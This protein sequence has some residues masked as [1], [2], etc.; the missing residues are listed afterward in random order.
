MNVRSSRV[1]FLGSPVDS[2]DMDEALQR[3]DSFIQSR[4]VHLVVAFNVPK[5]CKMRRDA[6]LKEVVEGADLILPE[7]VITLASRLCG[8][9]LKA[10]IGNDRLTEA[11]LPSASRKGYRVFFLGTEPARL[12]R[13]VHNLHVRYPE[14]PIAGY[15]HGYFRDSEVDEVREK[16]RASRPDILFVGMGTPRQEYWME[17]CGRTLGVP[18]II[19]VGG[20][21]D[22]MA[23]IKRQC[24][25]W[26]RN[27]GLEW[28]Y[29]VAED[30][31]GK[32]TRY[33]SALP[34]FVK[35]LITKGLL[36]RWLTN[37]NVIEN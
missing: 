11:L 14:L 26:I 28:A 25:D 9:R 15:H 30:P 36:P 16:I 20:T 34:W 33:T 1:E 13:M 4:S 5:L 21:L 7:Q 27:A 10:Y 32:F 31:K 6:R 2:L 12:E 29:R 18:V 3:I 19:G 8:N 22:V 23:G 37:R 17:S 35:E 24:P